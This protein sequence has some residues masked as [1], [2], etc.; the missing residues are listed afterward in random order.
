MNRYLFL[1]LYL[2][3]FSYL[4][5]FSQGFNQQ[6]NL[7]RGAAAGMGMVQTYDNRYEGVRGTPN[8]ET[9]F[10][11]GEVVFKTGKVFDIDFLN[12]N[13]FENQLLYKK[14]VN[15]PILLITND[16]VSEFSI[17]NRKFISIESSESNNELFY[18]QMWSNKELFLLR[19]NVKKLEKADYQGAYSANK[20]FD[21]FYDKNEYY[22][23]SNNELTSIKLNKKSVT[24]SFGSFFP[25]LEDYIKKNKV[26]VKNVDEL[27]VMLNKLNNS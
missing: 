17:G 14:D 1:C 24:Q 16:M 11:K 3:F 13:A 18:E 15:S 21:E 27:V 5:S 10:Q 8:V 26:D 6:D 19:L 22:L 23:F 2:L 12:Y 4:P 20:K 25:G 7:N 9:E